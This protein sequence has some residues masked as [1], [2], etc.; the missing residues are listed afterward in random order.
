MRQ[1]KFD[2][3]Y[4]RVLQNYFYVLEKRRIVAE[5]R[6]EELQGE[7]KKRQ[8]IAN[9]ARKNRRV[10]EIL[11]ENKMREHTKQLE[12]RRKRQCR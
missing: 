6:I 7:L 12:K 5:R 4:T 9:E 8:D 10:I 1:G 11:R 3:Q 2:V